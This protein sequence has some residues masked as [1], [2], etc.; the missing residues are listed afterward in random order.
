MTITDKSGG[1][2]TVS[3]TT[4]FSITEAPV[5]GDANG[6]KV[7]NVADIVRLVNDHAPQTKIDEVVKIIFGK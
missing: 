2:Y 5:P 7:V 4:T 6:D 1:N 3:G